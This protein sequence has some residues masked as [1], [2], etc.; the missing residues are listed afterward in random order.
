ML[1]V[2]QIFSAHDQHLRGLAGIGVSDLRYTRGKDGIVQPA[3][4]A[5][6]KSEMLFRL[7]DQL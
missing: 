5:P 1:P 4:Q 7:L 3:G 2:A 6:T